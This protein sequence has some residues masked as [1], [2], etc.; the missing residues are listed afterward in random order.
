MTPRI[1]VEVVGVRQAMATLRKLDK[2]AFFESVKGV[3]RAAQPLADAITAHY[4]TSPFAG[5]SK[6]GF[7][8]SGRTG[9]RNRGKATVKY[10]GKR[11]PDGTYPI[12]AVRFAGAAAEMVDMAGA[13]NLA[14]QLGG[15]PSRGVWPIADSKRDE[16][17]AAIEAAVNIAVDQLNSELERS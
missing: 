3:K 6:D 10:G 9:W 13:G 15:S 4:A 5:R 8:H 7:D 17:N 16:V 1:E 2:Q 12:A 11:R 14:D